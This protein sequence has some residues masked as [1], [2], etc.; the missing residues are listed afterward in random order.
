MT[1]TSPPPP[2][3]TTAVTDWEPDGRRQFRIIRSSKRHLD[4]CVVSATAVQLDDGSIDQG[5][6]IEP[7]KVWVDTDGGLTVD[8]ARAL[9][10]VLLEVAAE[11]DGWRGIA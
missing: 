11:V 4:G 5:D 1:T 8:Q 6:A 3:G 7:P 2:A 9:A 10:A